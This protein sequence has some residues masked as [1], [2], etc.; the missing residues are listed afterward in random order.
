M[1]PAPLTT[2]A[3]ASLLALSAV[4]LALSACTVTVP[5]TV[6]LW[7]AT[8]PSLAPLAITTSALVV[9]VRVTFFALT[10]TMPLSALRATVPLSFT[11]CE[12]V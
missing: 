6:A 12:M 5:F 3:L 1:L 4:T 2:G 7:K 10:R 9:P 11:Y 8:E